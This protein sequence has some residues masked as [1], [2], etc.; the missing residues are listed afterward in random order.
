M[1]RKKKGGCERTEG[2]HRFQRRTSIWDV[3]RPHHASNL[4]HGLQIGTEPAVHREDLSVDYGG[5]GKAIE[6]IRKRLP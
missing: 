4:F 3:R 1:E 2:F 6:A 5:D